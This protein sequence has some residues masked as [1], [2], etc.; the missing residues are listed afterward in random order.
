MGPVTFKQAVLNRRMLMC[1]FTGLV[2]GIPLYVLMS[3]V[4]A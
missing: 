1:I 4:P 3:L 2:S